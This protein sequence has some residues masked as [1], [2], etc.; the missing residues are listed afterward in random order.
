MWNAIAPL[1][2][3]VDRYHGLIIGFAALAAVLLLNQLIYR[4]SWTSY[5]TREDYLAAHPGCA[6]ADG[7]VCDRCR[8]K[9]SSMPV[10]GAGRIY[11]C[12]WC[13]TDLYRV[14]RG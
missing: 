10:K 5:P 3:F 2:E 13:E 9:A 1:L 6:T 11:R 7:V 8:Q 12:A 14:D 4:R